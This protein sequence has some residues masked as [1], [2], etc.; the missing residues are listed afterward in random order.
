VQISE[1]GLSSYLGESS[2]PIDKISTQLE[3]SFNKDVSCLLRPVLVNRV[4]RTPQ[5]VPE[6]SEMYH[7]DGE[8]RIY[9]FQE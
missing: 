1:V 6:F 9:D 4:Y 3:L 2:C 5:G 7:C 8:Y